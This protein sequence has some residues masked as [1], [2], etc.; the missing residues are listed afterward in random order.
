MHS[1][2]KFYSDLICH[3]CGLK[4]TCKLSPYISNSISQTAMGTDLG[5]T[6]YL[7]LLLS[8][9][10]KAGFHSRKNRNPFFSCNH[11]MDLG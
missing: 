7:S 9:G 8:E 4:L 11:L 1:V 6:Y 2:Q 5:V 10:R 3:G